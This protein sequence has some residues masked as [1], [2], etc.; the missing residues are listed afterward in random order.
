MSSFENIKKDDLVTILRDGKYPRKIVKVEKVNKTTFKADG[1]LF[2]M[3]GVSVQGDWHK[4]YCKPYEQSD[5]DYIRIR[6]KQHKLRDLF[7]IMSKVIYEKDE[8]VV[9]TYLDFYKEELKRI[10]DAKQV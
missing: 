4:I 7:E 3:S 6:N 2:K 1:M 8:K 5:S 9:D 10:K